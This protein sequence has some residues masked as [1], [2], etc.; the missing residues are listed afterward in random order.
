MMPV[1]MLCKG[2]KKR[3]SGQTGHTILCQQR[4]GGIPLLTEHAYNLQYG[5]DK[6]I[7]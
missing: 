1:I 5:I 2:S 3:Q 6:S 4:F 7:I